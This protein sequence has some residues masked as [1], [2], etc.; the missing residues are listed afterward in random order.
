[1]LA[2]AGSS[3]PATGLQP[4]RTS[5]VARTAPYKAHGRSG[6][7]AVALG[8]ITS[9]LAAGR[10]RKELLAWSPV[11]AQRRGKTHRN[12][13]VF[14]DG[15]AGTTGLQVRERLERHP[16]IELLSIAPELRKDA[17]ARREAFKEAD[18]AVLCLP[19]DAAI[20]AV[21][22]CEDFDTILVDAS[23]AHR[24]S[25]D[26]VY[27]FPEMTSTHGEAVA[28]S[29]R[30]ANP[31]CYPTGF[32]GLIRP[33][34]DAGLLPKDAAL[35]VHAISGYSGGG[36]GLIEVFED[37][38]HEPW[39]AYG[40]GLAHKH[41]PEMKKCTGLDEEPIFCPAVG[42]FR[43]GMVVSVPLRF[44]QLKKGTTLK[45]VHGALEAHYADS[46]FVRVAPLN[47]V[48]ELERGNFLRPDLLNDTNKL[49]LFCFGN[50]EKGTLWLAAR[51]DN[52]G[53]GA[54]GACV[55][56]LNLALGYDE[57]LG[58]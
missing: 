50:E 24:V 45:D 44:S 7:A 21:A 18:A 48:D 52:L 13:K 49:E 26:W 56:N 25:D 1:M 42:D 43:Q 27:G 22:M 4:V 58:L 5:V 37:K 53:K 8:A 30:I 2:L 41:L 29:K 34:T 55:Q 28:A 47:P 17:D 12:A 33:L 15:E 10:R 20:A 40:F 14:I 19:D 32:I 57:A 9:V 46:K 3:A 35:V 6:H 23:T 38:D 16:E 39:G 31:G 36:K 11:Q 51:L 54:S